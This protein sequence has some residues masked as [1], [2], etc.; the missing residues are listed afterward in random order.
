MFA[1]HG[2]SR[3]WRGT[4]GRPGLVGRACGSLRRRSDG[5]LTPS[6]SASRSS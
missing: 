5:G 2:E 3:S 4:K 6:L 1:S